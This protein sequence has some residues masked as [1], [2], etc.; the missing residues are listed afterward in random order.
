MRELEEGGLVKFKWFSYSSSKWVIKQQRQLATSTKH[1]AQ[2]L[3][4]NIQCS[5]ES[6]SFA[7]EMKTSSWSVVASHW[8]LMKT[9]W[10]DHQSWS[11]Y[12]YIRNC[13]VLN[14]NHSTVIQH[15]KGKEAQ[16]VGAS[17]AD[18]KFLKIIILKGLFLFCAIT[19]YFSIRLWYVTKSGFYMTTSDN[20]FSSWTEKKL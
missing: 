14:A 18:Q 20:Q 11:F 15:W 8:K 16:Y 9:S 2:E 4:T 10:E 6:R 5:G 7:K 12:N 19:N 1:L 17:W 13:I 3:L